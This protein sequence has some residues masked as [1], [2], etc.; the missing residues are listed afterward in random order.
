MVAVLALLS[1]NLSLSLSRAD[2]A[3]IVI[4]K[5]RLL[6][7]KADTIAA[8]ARLGHPVRRRRAPPPALCDADVI[9]AVRATTSGGDQTRLIDAI[10]EAG[11]DHVRR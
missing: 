6:C 1:T 4:A 9:S 10:K 2:L 8:S 3:A 5:P 7:T 11:G